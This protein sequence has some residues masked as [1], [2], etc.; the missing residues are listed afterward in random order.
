M[1]KIIENK[2]FKLGLTIFLIIAA[3]IV[4]FFL[5]F[6]INYVIDVISWIIKLISPFIIGFVFAYLLNPIVDFFQNK[7]FLKI[8]KKI[9][10][11]EEKK[12]KIA[13]FSSILITCVIV[14]A[15][16]LILF[17]FIIP[18]LLKS[19]EILI[20]NIP[21]YLEQI[22]NYLL[23][24]IE[25]HKDLENIVINNY[26]A[27]NNY[28]LNLINN[29]FLP[30]I[31]EWI[32]MFSNGLFGAIKVLYNIII[33]FIISIYFL[34]DKEGFKAQIKKI[35]YAF[36]SI[37]KANNLI[38]NA[39]HTDKIFGGFIM[40]KILVC[41]LVAII[42]FVFL[43]IFRVPYAILIASLVGITNIIPYFGPFIG[44]VPSLL[45]VL[46]QDPS[47]F[48]LVLIYLVAIQQIEGYYIEP[49]L[50][51]MKTGI[52]SFWVLFAIIIFGGAFGI[53]GMIVGVPIFAIIYGYVD[54]KINKILL[55]KNLPVETSKYSNIDKISIDNK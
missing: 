48:W 55:K 35:L 38:E 12:F 26:D 44:G 46:L 8:I 22:K 11:K 27:I 43:T 28:L 51:G 32:V 31:E 17:D 14:I 47:K 13:R 36:F 10:I 34:H 40:S 21:V 3:C 15:I 4:F 54:N 42:T 41:I 39:K 1:K 5:I 9:K 53:T 18:E 29:N 45:I 25:N 24:L 6:K 19:L 49:K 37:K 30:K 50:T 33:G 52:K 20:I 7:F 23:R 16:I 2:Y